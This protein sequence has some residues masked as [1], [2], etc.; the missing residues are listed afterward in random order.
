MD[1]EYIGVNDGGRMMEA[2]IME[3]ERWWIQWVNYGE[4]EIRGRNRYRREYMCNVKGE[5][6]EQCREYMWRAK[7]LGY[8]GDKE[9]GKYK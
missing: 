1:S 7:G 4:R 6:G 3:G 9:L 5:G 2:E 8:M